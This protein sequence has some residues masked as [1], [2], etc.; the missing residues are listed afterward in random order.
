MKEKF[1]YLEESPVYK[2]KYCIRLN[3]S[4]FLFPNGT[5]GSYGVIMARVMGL[6]FPDFLRYCRDRLG[7][8]LIGKGSIYVMPYFD[9]TPEVK[10]LVKLMNARL[11]Y[12]K[13]CIEYPYNYVREGGTIKL[14]PLE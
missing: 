2:N 7:A 1:F 8:E 5:S 10:Q 4:L 6:S 14:E 3:H 12:A 9:N 11:E 13:N